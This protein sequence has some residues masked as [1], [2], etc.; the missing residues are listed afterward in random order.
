[1]C[2]VAVATHIYVTVGM[3]QQ[4]LQEFAVGFDGI[5]HVL[6]GLARLSWISHQQVSKAPQPL[7]LFKL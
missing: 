5:L 7:C 2:H 1:M 3:G 6:L 4:L